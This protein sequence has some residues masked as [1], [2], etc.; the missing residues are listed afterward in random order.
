MRT[1][2]EHIKEIK[3]RDYVIDAK[4]ELSAKLAAANMERST[5][6]YNG[7]WI[8]CSERLPENDKDVLLSFSSVD[9]RV[10][11]MAADDCFYVYGDGFVRFENTSA[12]MPLPEPYSQKSTD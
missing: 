9:I 7:G 2:S 4:E 1:I 10:G 8:P 5:A 6:Y 11:Y 3:E 12:W